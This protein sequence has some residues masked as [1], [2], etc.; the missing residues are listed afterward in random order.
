MGLLPQIDRPMWRG[1]WGARRP[2]LLC[3]IEVAQIRRLLALLGGHQV[4]FRALE[5][6]LVAD[7]DQS[8]ALHAHILGPDRELAVLAPVF[9]RHRPWMRQRMVDDGQVV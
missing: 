5:I 3:L 9:F 4:A 2:S 8:A 6:H 7:E 1:L